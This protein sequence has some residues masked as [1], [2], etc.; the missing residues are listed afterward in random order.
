MKRILALILVLM[1]LFTSCGVI[2]EELLESD[3][4][5]GILGNEEPKEKPDEIT[6][7]PQD[8]TPEHTHSYEADVVAPTCTE[9]GYTT[10][11]CSS[12]DHQYVGDVLS[13]LGHTEV[14]VSGKPATETETG[15]TDGKK[16]SVCNTV[17][18][19]QKEIP[20]TGHSYTSEVIAPPCTEDGY[21]KYTCSGC[22]E[23]YT[24]DIVVALGHTEV[25][26][27]G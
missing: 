19:E 22:G 7:K 6:D 12:C 17:T 15:L 14:V 27:N 1:L 16:C 13:A 2:P 26:V 4:L 21:T 11:T 3:I 5:G 25:K 23:S 8:N 20:A 18:V 24:S 9:G 10:Y